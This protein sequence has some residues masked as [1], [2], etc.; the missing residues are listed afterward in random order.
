MASRFETAI[1][2]WPADLATIGDRHQLAN[3]IDSH[4]AEAWD[5]ALMIPVLDEFL[6]DVGLLICFELHGDDPEWVAIP[7]EGSNTW[8]RRLPGPSCT[9]TVC[10][11][12]SIPEEILAITCCMKAWRNRLSVQ[13]FTMS[14][15]RFGNPVHFKA[16]SPVLMMNLV[17]H[18]RSIALRLGTLQSRYQRVR[19]LI[20]GSAKVIPDQT[21]VWSKKIRRQPSKRRLQRKT[22][23]A[24]ANLNRKLAQ[25]VQ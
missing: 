11:V 24:Q 18:A 2:P 23:M 15:S 22:D 9:L 19:V 14:G 7:E 4:P 21:V 12:R 10:V 16:S 6:L 8:A 17:A 1:L 13:Y 25:L 3:A 20:Q 5:R